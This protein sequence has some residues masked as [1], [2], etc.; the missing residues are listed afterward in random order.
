MEP[1]LD[2]IAG[3][4]ATEFRTSVTEH[5]FTID[6]IRVGPF[7]ERRVVVARL[8]CSHGML[9]QLATELQAVWQAWIWRS[10]APED[11]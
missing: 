7:D 9:G 3:V 1:E 5:E 8:A 11:E 10:S 2:D 4:W 6:F